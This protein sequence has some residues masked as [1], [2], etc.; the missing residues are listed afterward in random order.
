M[1]YGSKKRKRSA[2]VAHRKGYVS[3]EDE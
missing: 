3:V 1:R 2:R